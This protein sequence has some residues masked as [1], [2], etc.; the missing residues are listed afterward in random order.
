MT[1]PTDAWVKISTASGPN[2]SKDGTRIFHLRG[3]QPLGSGLPQVWV[4]DADG[5]NAQQLSAHEEKVATLRRAPN[6][7]RLIWGIDA[8][9][10]ERQQLWLLEPGGTPRALTA[11]PEV[12]HDLGGFSPD[13]SRI[14]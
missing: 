2:F 12:I 14:A 13:G 7:D 4:M 1:I 8:G 9:G 3:T 5:G 11:A 6:D 10:D